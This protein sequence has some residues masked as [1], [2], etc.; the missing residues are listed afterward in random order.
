MVGGKTTVNEWGQQKDN[1]DKDIAFVAKLSN[2]DQSSSHSIYPSSLKDTHSLL[3]FLFA[4]TRTSIICT[5]PRAFKT[6]LAGCELS[7]GDIWERGAAV[8]MLPTCH[9]LLRTLIMWCQ[10]LASAHIRIQMLLNL[11]ERC[12]CCTCHNTHAAECAG[13]VLLLH[14]P[15]YRCC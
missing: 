2:H 5:M 13:N 7:A 14:M 11:H 6:L 15:R 8:T 3:S 10:L 4:L 1:A 9:V 12:C